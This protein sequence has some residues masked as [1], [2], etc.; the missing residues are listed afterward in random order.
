MRAFHRHPHVVREQRLLGVDARRQQPGL[1]GG[2]DGLVGAFGAPAVQDERARPSVTA[3]QRAS[4]RGAASPSCSVSRRACP[5]ASAARPGGR[6]A[7]Q[8][9]RHLC[10]PPRMRW[11]W[12]SASVCD[13]AQDLQDGVGEV[14][15]PPAGPETHLAEGLAVREGQR[16]R[17]R[18]T[19][20]RSRRTS[21]RPGA[22]TGAVPDLLDAGQV[23][24]GGWRPASPPGPR[25][26]PARRRHACGDLGE[27][28]RQVRGRLRVVRL[29]AAVR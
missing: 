20:R 17:R 27:H 5:P 25:P 29:P 19:R 28:R 7:P 1:A 26:P 21:A 11:C 18:T 6:V 13:D 8:R 10:A 23:A 24:G 9:Q 12:S 4:R 15:V 2:D 22:R 16:A 3:A 14:G